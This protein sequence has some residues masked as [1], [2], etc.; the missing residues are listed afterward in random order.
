MTALENLAAGAM[1]LVSF[2]LS[3]LALRAWN[4]KRSDK[5]LLIA[6]AFLLFFLKAAIISAA[7]FLSTSWAEDVLP[8]SVLIDLA[9]LGLFYF[10][11]FAQGR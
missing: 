5:V 8:A 4:H 9:I 2:V 10:A 1:L 6:G 7:L 11:I 3:L